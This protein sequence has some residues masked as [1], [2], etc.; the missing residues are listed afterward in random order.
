M[1]FLRKKSPNNWKR[2]HIYRQVCMQTHAHV[3]IHRY[4]CRIYIVF[5][6][7]MRRVSNTWL[8][9]PSNTWILL[10]STSVWLWLSKQKW[11][12]MADKKP[13]QEWERKIFLLALLLPEIC[14]SKSELFCLYC[15]VCSHWS[16]TISP[17]KWEGKYQMYS[18]K[19]SPHWNLMRAIAIYAKGKP[20]FPSQL[21]IYILLIKL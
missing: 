14:R 11:F 5:Q 4:M 13:D 17:F 10:I 12:H 6:H 18:A 21:A 3:C 19:Q 16:L 9:T 1:K 8:K 20:F 15:S 7:R 2:K